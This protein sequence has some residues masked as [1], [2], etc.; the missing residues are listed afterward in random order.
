MTILCEKDYFIEPM[1]VQQ[2]ANDHMTHIMDALLMQRSHLLWHKQ[3]FTI[4]ALIIN[5]YNN[6]ED[7]TYRVS[8]Y[9][10]PFYILY[11]RVKLGTEQYGHEFSEQ[12][13]TV[14]EW[15]GLLAAH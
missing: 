12:F 13:L 14:D 10:T 15:D 6:A 11:D 7:V 8:G 5:E 2:A 3:F 9:D 4:Y 1:L